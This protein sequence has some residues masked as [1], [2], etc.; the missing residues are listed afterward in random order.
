MNLAS[1]LRVRLEDSAADDLMLNEEL[2]PESGVLARQA[3]V[4]E[5]FVLF[6]ETI[7]GNSY[8]SRNS[9]RLRRSGERALR[10]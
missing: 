8:A 4:G 7:C 2:L 1:A 10:S 9:I 5:R 6:T 3:K